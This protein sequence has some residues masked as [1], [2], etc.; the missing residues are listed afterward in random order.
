MLLKNISENAIAIC[1]LVF[2]QK[3][4]K[5]RILLIFS[6]E[7]HFDYLSKTDG[8]H[9]SSVLLSANFKVDRCIYAK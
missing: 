9:K 5:K 2:M 8:V 1:K 7:A 6:D 4:L 3:K